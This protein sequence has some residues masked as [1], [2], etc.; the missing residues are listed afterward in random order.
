MSELDYHEH[1]RKDIYWPRDAGHGIE[2]VRIEEMKRQHAFNAY[3]RLVEWAQPAYT[4]AEAQEFPLTRALLRQAMGEPVWFEADVDSMIE[5]A[6]DR[7]R[8]EG[9]AE[10]QEQGFKEGRRQGQDEFRNQPRELKDPGIT[11][12]QI[13]EL[14]GHSAVCQHGVLLCSVC[15]TDQLTDK[16]SGRA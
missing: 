1:I 15:I 12:A 14:V 5:K 13:A 11:P 2:L 16:L 6:H 9:L 10:G 8:R 4:R 3:W 7:G